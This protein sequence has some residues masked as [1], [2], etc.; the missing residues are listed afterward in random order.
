[1]LIF[2]YRFENVVEYTK[3]CIMKTESVSVRLP[4]ETVGKV[5][6]K[7]GKNGSMSDYIK[8]LINFDMVCGMLSGDINR[9]NTIGIFPHIEEIS[10][11]EPLVIPEDPKPR[12]RTREPLT[13]EDV[14]IP[15]SPDI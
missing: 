5:R 2:E 3:S 13:Y 9:N 11:V 7:I 4:I 10:K 14:H 15:L 6:E 12:R 8:W 1:M